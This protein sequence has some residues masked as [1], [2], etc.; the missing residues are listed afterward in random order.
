MTL[1]F[2]YV[3]VCG[4]LFHATLINRGYIN[5]LNCTWK[6][7]M[8]SFMLSGKYVFITLTHVDRENILCPFY[9]YL[10]RFVCLSSSQII[11]TCKFLICYQTSP[12]LSFLWMQCSECFRAISISFICLEMVNKQSEKK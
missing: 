11:T 8:L 12:V 1:S 2:K 3:N 7:S 6:N 10:L 5:Y 9:G 4:D